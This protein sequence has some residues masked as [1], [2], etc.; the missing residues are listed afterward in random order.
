MSRNKFIHILANLILLAGTAAFGIGINSTIRIASAETHGI[1][2]ID[3]IHTNIGI[4]ARITN[5]QPNQINH[6]INFENIFI[7]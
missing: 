3:A 1:A 4:D 5:I 6:N 7:A 2:K